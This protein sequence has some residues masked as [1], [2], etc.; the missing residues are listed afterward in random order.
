MCDTCTQS[1]YIRGILNT[2]ANTSPHGRNGV[3]L[4]A[5]TRFAEL[6]ADLKLCSESKQQDMLKKKEQNHP[7]T[8]TPPPNLSKVPN[9]SCICL[10]C[11][12][13]FWGEICLC[14]FWGFPVAKNCVSSVPALCQRHDKLFAIFSPL[15]METQLVGARGS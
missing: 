14:C 6:R 13:C 4:T 8:P 5:L 7:K 3:S 1:K 15:Q 12:C 9:E 2:P 11:L 10:I